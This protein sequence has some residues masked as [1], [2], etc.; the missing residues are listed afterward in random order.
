L[1]NYYGSNIAWR[2][3]LAQEG[4]DATELMTQNPR[5]Y[6]EGA[7]ADIAANQMAIRMAKQLNLGERTSREE[8]CQPYRDNFNSVM[9][10]TETE[11]GKCESCEHEIEKPD[12]LVLPVSPR[13]P[14][15]SPGL[16][17]S[18]YAGCH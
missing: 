6:N 16:N 2:L 9:Q 17:C 1:T 13:N 8:F 11:P 18:K 15:P 10:E 12:D 5:E 4:V 14:Q 7:Q 3:G